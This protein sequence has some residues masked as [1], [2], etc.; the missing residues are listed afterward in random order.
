MR[1]PA[2]RGSAILR[3]VL[4]DDPHPDDIRH[5][6]SGDRTA[7]RALVVYLRPAIHGEVAAALDRRRGLGRGRDVRQEVLDLVQEVFVALLAD[8]GRILR[9]WN[10]EAGRGLRGFARMVTRHQVASILRSGKRSPWSDDPTEDAALERQAPAGEPT[11]R[12][13]SRAQLDALL[14]RLRAELDT[15]GWLLFERLYLD[16]APADAVAEELG[17]TRDAVYAW[18]ARFKRRLRRLAGQIGR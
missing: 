8:D 15:R 7:M 9:R 2:A 12:I 13:E 4:P 3:A 16:G 10:P 5:A 11:A 6:L 18:R 1:S 14:A 17:M